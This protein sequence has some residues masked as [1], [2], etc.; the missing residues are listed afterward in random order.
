MPFSRGV[1]LSA[2]MSNIHQRFQDKIIL[3]EHDYW[4]YDENLTLSFLKYKNYCHIKKK[5]KNPD[6]LW[7]S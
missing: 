6:Q 2:I 7:Q 5:K 1:L 3:F 4:L